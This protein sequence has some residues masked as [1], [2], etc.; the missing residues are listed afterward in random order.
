MLGVARRFGARAGV[1]EAAEGEVRQPHARAAHEEGGVDVAPEDGD[2][3]AVR[4]D[5]RCVRPGALDREP[6]AEVEAVVS[7]EIEIA[8]TE[9]RDALVPGA[10]Q[11]RIAQAGGERRVACVGHRVAGIEVAAQHLARAGQAGRPT[12][13]E[14]DRDHDEPFAHGGRR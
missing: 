6:G 7:A 4:V 8:G 2:G 14:R 1:A 13:C 5:A 9:L 12:A 3:G 10:L 11:L